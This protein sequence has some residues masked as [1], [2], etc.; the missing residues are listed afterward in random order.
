MSPCNEQDEWIFDTVKA[1]TVSANRQTQRRRKV[2]PARTLVYP[3]DELLDLKLEE[4]TLEESPQQSATVRK[5][6]LHKTPSSSGNTSRRT[7]SQRR[8]LGPDLSFGN[9]A[10]S[11]RQ[12]R[13][14]SDHSP[15]MSPEGSIANR[16]ENRPPLEDTMS[17][18][19]QLGRRAY[20]SAID[21]AFQETHAQTSSQAKREALARVASAWSALDAIDPEGE[22]H[23][24]TSMMS[25]LQRYGSRTAIDA[26]EL[27]LIYAKIISD[28]KLSN[29]LLPPS[30]Q[31]TSPQKPKLVLAQANPHLKSHR[32]RQS[33][34]VETDDTRVSYPA[35]MPGQYVPGKEHLQQLSNVL[36]G[37]WVDGLKN[38]W[39]VV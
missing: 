32:R 15:T 23:L 9:G 28:A 11:V 17:K 1:P 31:Q 2:S 4:L 27:L 10:S 14:V 18:E 20:A 19:G 29:A 26:L 38:R 36:Y 16:D 8:P 35:N 39:A 25:K 34:Q 22:L 5:I 30:K 33:L 3:D 12:F 24:L 37:R 21:M 13:R 6:S 7:S